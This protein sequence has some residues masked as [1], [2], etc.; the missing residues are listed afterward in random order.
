M[1]NVLSQNPM[2]IDT[3]SA[4]ALTSL[5][6]NVL[7]FVFTQ[8]QNATD[9][10]EVQNAAGN[11]IAFLKGNGDFENVIS[12]NPTRCKGLLVPVTKTDGTPNPTGT[13]LIYRT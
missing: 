6:L 4:S 5:G 13:L 11:P 12:N 7:Q 9:V 1:A 3:P 10:L 2:V 8:Y